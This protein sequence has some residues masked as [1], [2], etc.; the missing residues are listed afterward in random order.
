MMRDSIERDCAQHDL[1]DG[2]SVGMAQRADQTPIQDAKAI[3]VGQK[4][5]SGVR[6]AMEKSIGC[7]MEDRTGNQRSN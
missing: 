3:F 1:N 2:H 4:D 7:G 5:V 6:I